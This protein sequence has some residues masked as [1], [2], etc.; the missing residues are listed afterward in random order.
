[1][2]GRLIVRIP[3]IGLR[4]KVEMWEYQKAYRIK[5]VK[6][7]FYNILTCIGAGEIQVRRL[8]P[9]RDISCGR[10]KYRHILAILSI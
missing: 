8:F 2:G 5:S 7:L 1:M 10:N 3:I 4:G 9:S 6:A